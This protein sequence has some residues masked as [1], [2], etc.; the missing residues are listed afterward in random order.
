M[1]GRLFREVAAAGL[2]AG[3]GPSNVIDRAQILALP[4]PAQ[5][6]LQF[7]RIVGRQ[8]DWSFQL[9][10][11]GRFRTKP[12]QPWMKCQTLQYNSRLALARIFHISIRLGGLFP[13]VARDT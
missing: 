13:V 11:T 8:Q 2:P 10:F 12:E 3:P 9:G 7:M 6:Y 5:R 1:R 4:E